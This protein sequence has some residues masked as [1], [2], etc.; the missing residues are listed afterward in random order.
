MLCLRPFLINTLNHHFTL[1]PYCFVFFIADWCLW[2]YLLVYY[3]YLVPLSLLSLL[4][5]LWEQCLII[6]VV[7]M[8]CSSLGSSALPLSPGV[9]SNHVHWVGDTNHLILCHPLLLLPSVFPSI[10]VF[11]NESYLC[12]SWPTYSSFSNSP[13]NEY[14]GLTSLGLTGL[15]FLQSKGHSGVFSSTTTW[16]HQ[17]GAQLSLWSRSHVCTWLLEKS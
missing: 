16:K 4:Y 2:Y 8:N 6:N 11:S 5:L 12:V 14:S 7:G 1:S 17:L 3:L 10:R 13:S 9:C 15:I